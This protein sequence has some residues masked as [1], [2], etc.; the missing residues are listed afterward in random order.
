MYNNGGDDMNIKTITIGNRT[1][2]Y[3]L[4]RKPIKRVYFRYQKD[5][6]L[7]SAPNHIRTSDI[8]F[9]FENNFDKLI[10]L[11][12]KHSITLFENQT[13]RIMGQDYTLHY[14]QSPDMHETCIYVRKEYVISDLFS[15][16]E[17]RLATYVNQK[18]ALYYPH[19]HTTKPL[20]I[21]KYK[22][23]KHYY[24]KYRQSTNQITFN[25]N[26]AFFE[27]EV[28]DYIIVHELAHMKLL[29]HQAS[30]YAI[31]KAILPNYMTLKKRVRKE[32]V[33]L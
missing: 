11:M 13:L 12:N 29:H 30:F 2:D 5:Y 3:K 20:P 33:N 10:K 16:I 19:I 4:V 8:T 23:V 17:P 6:F 26:I 1:F 7:I 32:G 15:L 27:E 31:I 14:G 24:G 9:L 21:V 22:R 25:P 28:I 18:I